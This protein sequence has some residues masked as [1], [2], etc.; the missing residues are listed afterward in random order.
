MIQKLIFFKNTSTLDETLYSSPLGRISVRQT[1]I[2][3]MGFGVILLAAITEYNANNDIS[4]ALFYLPFLLIPSILGLHKPKVL[5]A[6]QMLISML[7]FLIHGT[8]APQII[9]RTKSKIRR[10]DKDNKK[11]STSEV[12]SQCESMGYHALIT[13]HIPNYKIRTVTVTDL[14]KPTRLKLVIRKPDGNAFVNHFVSVYLDGIRI[15]AM[16]TDSIGE[17][18]SI[19]SPKYEGVHELKVMAK[20]YVEPVMNGKIRFRL[21]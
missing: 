15:T 21:G 18:E 1:L 10:G 14:A 13:E 3:G 7:V 2:L 17:I 11:R 19:M 5:T 6:D 20:G 4:S 16:T 12:D 9:I 8:S